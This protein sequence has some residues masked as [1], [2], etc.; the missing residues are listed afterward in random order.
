MPEMSAQ[1]AG[2]LS[3]GQWLSLLATIPITVVVSWFVTFGEFK[4]KISGMEESHKALTIETRNYVIE[5]QRE[6]VEYW[7]Q[8]SAIKQE[9]ALL[10]QS[11][12][13]FS[14]RIRELEVKLDEVRLQ[15]TRLQ[16]EVRRNATPQ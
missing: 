4:E 10:Q 1:N 16:A 8:I 5:S 14:D 12:P 3:A 7:R 11:S 2:K 15:M 6:R 9:I 13:F